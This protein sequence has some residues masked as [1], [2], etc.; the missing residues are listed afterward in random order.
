MEDCISLRG[1]AIIERRKK[2]G[3]VIDREEIK[4][5]IIN[6]GKERVAKLIGILET[7][8]AGFTHIAIGESASGDSV[9]VTDTELVSEAKRESAT[10]NYEA[11]YKATFEKTFTFDTAESYSIKEAGLFDGATPTGSTM[12]DRFLFSEKAVDSD[13]DLYVKITITVS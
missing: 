7:G 9:N 6:A 8:I 3:T 10:R 5:T 11:S 2:D 13:T 12:L 1:D 4:N